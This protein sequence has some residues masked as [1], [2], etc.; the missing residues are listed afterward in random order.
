MNNSLLIVGVLFLLL[1]ILFSGW[2]DLER[3]NHDETNQPPLVTINA[4]ITEGFAP[5]TVEFDA[6]CTDED[7]AIVSYN[8]S[9][10]D[11]TT[12]D[13]KTPIHTF[14]VFGSYRVWVVVTDDDGGY[15]YDTIDIWAKKYIPPTPIPE[16]IDHNAYSSSNNVYVVGLVKN[17][18][19]KTIEFLNVSVTLYDASN[20][21]IDTDWTY[22]N[23]TIIE[24]GGE[25]CFK[26]THSDVSYYDHYRI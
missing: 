2:N 17:V 5:L 15:N 21:E 18:A 19:D 26:T 4:D 7:G 10:S 20:N 8:W 3:D 13:E 14:N 25:A 12:S 22:A 1:S 16:V 11:G 24:A 6:D 9:F 23:P